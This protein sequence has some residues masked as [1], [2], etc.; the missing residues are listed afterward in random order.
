MIYRD[1]NPYRPFRR[2]V[3]YDWG[4]LA[5]GESMT[6]HDVPS[7]ATVYTS[8]HRF[9]IKCWEMGYG[10]DFVPCFDFAWEKGPYEH[11]GLTVT[12]TRIPD[13]RPLDPGETSRRRKESE[14]LATLDEQ[15]LECKAIMDAH[16]V[17]L[18]RRS[19][20]ISRGQAAPMT[21]LDLIE[22]ASAYDKRHGT[23]LAGMMAEFDFPPS[24]DD[25]DE[26]K[27][28]NTYPLRRHDDRPDRACSTTLAEKLAK[29]V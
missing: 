15:A 12:I 16:D 7:H 25:I 1:P 13:G 3:K 8:L 18:H 9:R 6:V 26:Y 22:R 29:G 2:P 10:G 4:S 27:P 21:P 5:V 28:Y 14:H 24:L 23:R 11:S 19:I 20:A 17:H